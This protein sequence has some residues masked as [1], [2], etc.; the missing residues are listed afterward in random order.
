MPEIVVGVA[1][2]DGHEEDPEVALE[3][4]LI[5]PARVGNHLGE[6]ALILRVSH[7]A[8]SISVFDRPVEISV[9]FIYSNL[10]VVKP[11]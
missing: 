10:H 2:R 6:Y 5:H 1:G 9:S 8:F 11:C 7:V 3:I 4:S